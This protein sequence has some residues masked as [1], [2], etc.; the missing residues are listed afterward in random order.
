M[1][2]VTY[3]IGNSTTKTH[4]IKRDLNFKFK[5]HDGKKKNFEFHII[6]IDK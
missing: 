4:P 1:I 3:L 6:N 5:Y 2:S